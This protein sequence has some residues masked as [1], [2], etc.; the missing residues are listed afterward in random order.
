M[1]VG[2][3]PGASGALVIMENNQ[4]I[5]WMRMPTMKIGS[6]TRVNAAAIASLLQNY[7]ITKAYVENVHSMPKQGVASS[8]N[9]GHSCGVVEGVVAACGI[10]IHMVTP[11]TWKK[12]AGLIGQDKDAARSAAIRLWPQWHALHKKLEGQA[13][14]DAALIAIYGDRND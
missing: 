3:D 13:M 10:P 5:E 11:Q 12:R 7:Q 9:F 1:I 2:I 4:P 14:A 8:F 6:T